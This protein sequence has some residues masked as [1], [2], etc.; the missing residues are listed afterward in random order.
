MA[1]SGT[2]SKQP[3][4]MEIMNQMCRDLGIN[5]C[6]PQ[7]LLQM[8]DIAYSLTKNVLLEARSVAEFNGKKFIERTDVDFALKSF[9]EK[10]CKDRPPIALMTE[11]AAEK[12]AQPL[13]QIR[14]NYG[15]RLPNDRFCQ[16]QQNFIYAD[17]PLI[18]TDKGDENDVQQNQQTTEAQQS[19]QKREKPESSNNFNPDLVT[20]KMLLQMVQ[21]RELFQM[22]K[23]Q[24]K[25][26]L[27]IMIYLKI[28]ST[29]LILLVMLWC[30]FLIFC[31]A[32]LAFLTLATTILI[33]ALCCRRRKHRVMKI[34]SS[35]R[36]HKAS[37]QKT[38]SSKLVNSVSRTNSTLKKLTPPLSSS[39]DL[40]VSDWPTPS[41]IPEL[42]KGNKM[43]EAQRSDDNLMRL[44]DG[45]L[46][47][48]YR[49]VKRLGEGG[50][51]VVYKVITKN[52]DEY[53]MKI[54]RTNIKKKDQI[55]GFRVLV[56]GLLSESLSK[57]QDEQPTFS[58]K[59][60]TVLRIGLQ[61]IRAIAFLHS[62][63][64]IHRDIKPGNFAI[65]H[66]NPRRIFLLDFGLS[67]SLKRR[68]RM[69]IRKPRGDVPFR[70][71]PG[72]CSLNA[73]QR[74][75]HGR[76]DDI[77]GLIYM[78]VDLN[79]GSLPW[80]GKDRKET[81][82]L[83]EKLQDEEYMFSCPIAFSTI[84]G[85][86][87]SLNYYQRPDYEGLEHAFVQM[88]K[89]R[90]VNENQK[91][92]WEININRA[93]KKRSKQDTKAQFEKAGTGS[94]DTYELSEESTGWTM[95]LDGNIDEMKKRKKK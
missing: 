27:M 56:M 91:M 19:L 1:D 55:F 45:A 31:F 89:V 54:E 36:R 90:G 85:N 29:T 71:T 13:P 84:L 37:S 53:A 59:T 34:P 9:N 47:G 24:N 6:E 82:V 94:S 30:L 26:I 17:L 79:V 11:L 28:T 49:I 58:F 20:N 65:G 41:K 66:E 76:H 12:N 86:L 60:G 4:L 64:F 10:F 52:G 69:K 74:K 42:V 25:M 15:L 22:T 70:G 14:Q 95:E 87:R 38:S 88:M 3:H 2:S 73:H 81:G 78:L 40:A 43:A 16:L 21:E 23:K 61:A 46:V 77:W 68:G 39:T 80:F 5:E 32:K 33:F 35:L 7:L 83:K 75:E 51:G 18:S 72:Y 93:A 67:R 44:N 62:I 92:D 57:L 63:Y 50:C 8:C 48:N